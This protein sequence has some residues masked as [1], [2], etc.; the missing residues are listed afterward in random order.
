MRIPEGAAP[1]HSDYLLP[2]E[3]FEATL[4][5]EG[6]YD[7]F[8]VPHELAGMVGRI[9]VGRPIGPGARPFDHF[10]ALPQ[11]RS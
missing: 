6:V 2:G 4:A 11:A 3:R 9:V 1:W 8:R 7:Y 5:A 10:G